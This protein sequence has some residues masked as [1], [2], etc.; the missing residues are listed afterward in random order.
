LLL[1]AVIVAVGSVLLMHGLDAHADPAARSIDGRE[2][3]HDAE[4]DH[5]DCPDCG[6]HVLAACMAVLA[7]AAVACVARSGPLARSSLLA[8]PWRSP[9]RADLVPFRPPRWVELSVMRC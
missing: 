3:P 9:P 6:T 7:A 2:H 1:V 5:H 4:D 8:S